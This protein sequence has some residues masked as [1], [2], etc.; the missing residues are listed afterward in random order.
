MKREQLVTKWMNH[1]LSECTLYRDKKKH[2]KFYYIKDGQ[3]K[4]IRNDES[5]SIDIEYQ[6]IWAKSRELFYSNGP[7][8]YYYLGFWAKM[9]NW[10][11]YDV[12]PSSDLDLLKNEMEPV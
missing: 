3:I 11:G 5:K 12:F 8:F 6:S 2:N 7:D 9:N 1:I 4:I 10:E